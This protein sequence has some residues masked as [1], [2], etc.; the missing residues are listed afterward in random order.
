MGRRHYLGH[1]LVNHMLG[2]LGISIHPSS[3]FYPTILI[4]WKD[5][6]DMFEKVFWH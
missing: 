2:V 3:H 4:R 1:M 5:F 6:K